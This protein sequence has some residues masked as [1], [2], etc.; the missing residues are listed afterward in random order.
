MSK[1]EQN[2]WKLL[3]KKFEPLLHCI[4]LGMP[5][6]EKIFKNAE[7]YCVKY[8]WEEVWST[9]GYTHTNLEYLSTTIKNSFP[10]NSKRSHASVF[11]GLVH[12]KSFFKLSDSCLVEDLLQ[13]SQLLHSCLMSSIYSRP[14]DTGSSSKYSL[15]GTQMG[16]MKFI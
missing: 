16:D 12:T 6:L 7:L 3:Y 2:P 15:A 11:Q 1:L 8:V 10:W 4:L 5:S 14:E 13:I 9:T